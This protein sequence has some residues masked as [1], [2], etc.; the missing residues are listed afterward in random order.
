MNIDDIQIE[1]NDKHNNTIEIEGGVG[2][3]LRDP[4]TSML[5][6]IKKSKNEIEQFQTEN[7]CF[8]FVNF[9]ILITSI[10]S[11]ILISSALKMVLTATSYGK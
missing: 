11:V 9:H 8:T 3:K 1:F 2:I 6:N 5:F 10:F 4:K 7:I